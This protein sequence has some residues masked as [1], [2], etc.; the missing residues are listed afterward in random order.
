MAKSKIVSIRVLGLNVYAT[1]II[2][3][4]HLS[5]IYALIHESYKK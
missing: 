2:K 5:I 3:I 1:D 4:L